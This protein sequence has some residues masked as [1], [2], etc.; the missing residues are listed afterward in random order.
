[1]ITIQSRADELYFLL[2][3]CAFVI[4]TLV[5]DCLFVVFVFW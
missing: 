5:D 2:S 1:L 4:T 3:Q